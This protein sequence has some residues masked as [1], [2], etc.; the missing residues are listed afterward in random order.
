MITRSFRDCFLGGPVLTGLLCFLLLG[1]GLNLHARE[2]DEPAK[3][4][5]TKAQKLVAEGDL[6]EALERFLT[7]VKKYSRTELAAL[8]WWEIYRINTHLENDEAAFEAL[9]RLIVEQ[10]GHF[11]K[12]HAAQLQMVRRLLGSGKDVRRSLE[13]VRKSQV[14]PPEVMV[15]MLKTVIKN[16]PQS[17]VGI[18]AHYY[19]A[20]AQEKAGEKKEAIA[21]HEDFAES[22][23]RHELADDAGYQVAYI[24]YKDWKTMKSTGPRQRE[25]AAIALAWFIA[26]FPESDK[27]AQAR[28][29]L[30]EVKA[31][32]QRELMSLARYY[33]SK[34]NEKAAAIYYEQI[35]TKF[36]ELV[37]ADTALREKI[38]KADSDESMVGPVAPRPKVAD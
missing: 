13:V 17:E 16:G 28:S 21:T 27:A 6:E 37:L 26:R 33:E 38:M 8:A 7:L 15:E 19:L 1:C 14:T 12:A 31:S 24:A 29:C 35:A 30:A 23:P 2:E 9:N 36:P 4:L 11:E 5:Y 25:G 3:H 10:P 32:E 22:Y 20:I 18:Q 34:G